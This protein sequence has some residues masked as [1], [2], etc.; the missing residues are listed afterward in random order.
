MSLL[1]SYNTHRTH[2]WHRIT[3]RHERWNEQAQRWELVADAR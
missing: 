1:W 3:G 2:R